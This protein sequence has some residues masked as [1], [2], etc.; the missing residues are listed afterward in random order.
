MC[1]RPSALQASRNAKAFRPVDRG[2]ACE[3]GDGA[4]AWNAH[5]SPADLLLPDEV[6]NLFRLAGELV[7]HHGQDRKQRLDD[8]HHGGIVTA[9]FAHAAGERRPR[10]RPELEPGLAQDRPGQILDRPQLRSGLCGAPPA[11]SATAGT[12]G[13]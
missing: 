10:G 4:D 3:R 6:L 12:D 2:A 7:P 1:L 8:R 11:A 5:Q 9:E 13:S